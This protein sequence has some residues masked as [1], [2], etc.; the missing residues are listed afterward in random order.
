MAGASCVF[1]EARGS[2]LS[3]FLYACSI[4][5]RSMAQPWAKFAASA[6]GP[7]WM[8]A[9]KKMGRQKALVCIMPVCAKGALGLRRGSRAYRTAILYRRIPP[10]HRGRSI[11]YVEL[12][13]RRRVSSAVKCPASSRLHVSSQVPAVG[14]YLA[15]DV[16][17]SDVN[18][19][20]QLNDGNRA[21]SQSQ[22][23][24]GVTHFSLYRSSVDCRENDRSTSDKFT[25]SHR[26]TV[27]RFFPLIDKLLSPLNLR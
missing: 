26:E 7:C 24:K 17:S 21:A 23:D 11:H 5:S 22:I 19:P 2:C 16:D 4:I 25:R 8:P 15:P 18:S 20:H 12:S 6:A 10:V 3:L 9:Y 1:H 13:I 27:Q 14:S